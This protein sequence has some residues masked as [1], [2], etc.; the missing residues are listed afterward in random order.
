ME[1]GTDLFSILAG[2]SDFINLKKI[3]G[4]NVELLVLFENS[5]KFVL[6]HRI[7]SLGSAKLALLEASI[8]S[9]SYYKVPIHLEEADF[10]NETGSIEKVKFST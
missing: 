7:E 3:H 2:S 1:F 4:G 8:S 5:V 10:W 6:I 9:S